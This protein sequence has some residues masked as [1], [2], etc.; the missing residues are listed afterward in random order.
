MAVRGFRRMNVQR[1]EY[2]KPRGRFDTYYE[3]SDRN[4][5]HYE[6]STCPGVNIL[7]DPG[8]F[9]IIHD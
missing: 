1:Q 8:Q 3:L 4:R 7:L 6:A 9:G 2:K 5:L